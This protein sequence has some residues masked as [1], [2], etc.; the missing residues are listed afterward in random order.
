M[1]FAENKMRI[2]L[3]G[4]SGMLGNCIAKEF[5]EF[6]LICPG[7]RLVDVCNL[8]SL[9]S[10]AQGC[11]PDLIINASG[12]TNVDL[13]EDEKTKC[14]DTNVNGSRNIAFVAHDMGINCVH[15]SSD[16]VFSGNKGDKEEY[17]EE[18][19][20]SPLSFYG[21]T[22][23]YSEAF[24]HNDLSNQL[25]IRT[26]WLYSYSSKNFVRTMLKLFEQKDSVKVI[27]DVFGRTTFC[28]DLAKYTKKIAH[29]KGIYHFANSGVLS[30]YDFAKEI[31][32]TSKEIGL[33]KKDVEIIPIKNYQ[34]PAKAIRPKSSILST[35]KIEFELGETIEDYRDALSRCLLKIQR[36]V[37]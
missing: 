31:Y 33:I 12:Y 29:K 4:S 5:S 20:K 13:A 22:K 15:F 32:K 18:D 17:T 36:K 34:Y 26:S 23:S 10:F 6:N 28:D 27:D 30:W 9:Y 3:L 7:H 2:L 1:S 8:K 25:I 37:F 16:Y 35:K 14:Y 24:F 19:R 11:R 21:K